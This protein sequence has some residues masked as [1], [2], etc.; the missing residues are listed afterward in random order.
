MGF[1]VLAVEIARA[2]KKR[3]EDKTMSPKQLFLRD[4]PINVK[5]RENFLVHIDIFL[6]DNERKWAIKSLIDE[7]IS[8][9]SKDKEILK[10]IEL[11]NK[12]ED[13]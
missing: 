8:F 4:N 9:Y 6:E 1:I 5:H 11:M 2:I 3:K 12:M 10:R 13:E 7:Y